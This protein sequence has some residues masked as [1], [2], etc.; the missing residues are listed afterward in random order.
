MGTGVTCQPDLNQLISRN[1]QFISLA[2]Q[3]NSGLLVFLASVPSCNGM[4]AESIRTWYMLF[5]KIAA[6]TGFY[7]H[8]YFCFWKHS[9]SD[10]GFTSGFDTAPVAHIP[11]VPEIFRR[12]EVLAVIAIHQVAADPAT[13]QLEVLA[14]ASSALVPEVLTYAGVPETL[15]QPPLQHD[16]HYVFH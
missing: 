2:D 7:L 11:D 15:A 6:T 1:G 12:T 8:P 13:R 14:I 10:Y 16:L 3:G 9:N 4:S 5:T